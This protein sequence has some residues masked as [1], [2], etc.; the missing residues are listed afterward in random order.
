MNPRDRKWYSFNDSHVSS[1]SP[2]QH[3]TPRAYVLFYRRKHG[4]ARWA[5][6]TPLAENLDETAASANGTH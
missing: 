5:G 6:V 1:T 3:V 2:E 4:S